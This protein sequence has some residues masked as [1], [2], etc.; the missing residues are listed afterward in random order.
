M[1]EQYTP[2]QFRANVIRHLPEAMALLAKRCGIGLM[3]VPF[4]MDD[5]HEVA[6]DELNTDEVIKASIVEFNKGRAHP[7]HRYGRAAV[8]EAAE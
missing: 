2:E 1:T 3:D 7:V 4:T 5:L 6:L 8:K